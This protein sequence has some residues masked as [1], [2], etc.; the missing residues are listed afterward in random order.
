MQSAIQRVLYP[1]ILKAAQGGYKGKDLDDIFEIDNNVYDTIFDSIVNN[2]FVYTDKDITSTNL[3]EFKSNYEIIP[4]RVILDAG[5][6]TKATNLYEFI[7]NSF[8]ASQANIS[9]GA[10]RR[11][12]TSSEINDYNRQALLYTEDPSINYNPISNQ[13]ISDV[14]SEPK[15]LTISDFD[16]GSIVYDFGNDIYT[17]TNN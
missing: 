10:S 14:I 13:V 1:K 16:I 15:T 3:D 17:P 8:V 5:T 9:G 4:N 11:Y 12:T 6:N 7:V 2:S